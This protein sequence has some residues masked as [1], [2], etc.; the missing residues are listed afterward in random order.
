M[1]HYQLVY[2]D[3]VLSDYV[4]CNQRAHSVASISRDM[5]PGTKNSS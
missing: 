1:K 3:Y 2:T 5:A 4:K